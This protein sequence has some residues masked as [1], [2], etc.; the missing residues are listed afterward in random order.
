LDR[1][2]AADAGTASIS[3]EQFLKC[4]TDS[5]LLSAEDI[6]AFLSRLPA[7]QRQD[8][9]QLA[10]QLL[11]QGKLTRFQATMLL[12]GKVKGLVLGNYI[13]L[14]KLGQGGMGMVF[15]ARHRRLDRV[16]ALKVLP[17]AVAKDPK[18]V[19]RF[20]REV[21]AAAQLSHPN[22]V[23][24][25]DADQDRGVHFLVMEFVPGADLAQLVKQRG[26]LPVEQAVA[27]LA[28]AAQGLAHAHAHGIIHRDIK[29]GNLLLDSK[30]TV[31]VLDLGL[32][33]F[34]G[35][36]NAP[37]EGSGTEALTKSGSI[38]GTTDYMAP[39][40]ALNT[41]RADQRADIYSLGCTLYF[42]L[43][44][45]PMYGGETAMEKLLAHR[46]D[47][48][49]PLPNVSK[50]LQAVYTRMVAKKVNDRYP[51]MTEVGADLAAC[52]KGGALTH[53][54]ED[55]ALAAGSQQTEAK[56]GEE[57]WA[58]VGSSPDDSG[59]AQRRKF[60]TG[61]WLLGTGAGALVVLAGLAWLITQGLGEKKD[62]RNVASQSIAP[63]QG[64]ATV[65]PPVENDAAWLK[66]V[67]ALPPEKQVEAVAA[68]LKER[69]P[70]FDGK[71][72]HTV[73]RGVVTRLA[74]ATDNVTDI[75]PVRAL[76]G[77]LIL[78]C[79]ASPGQRGKL[80]DLTPLKSMRLTHLYCLFTK[81]SDLSPLKDMKLTTLYCAGTAVSELSPLKDMALTVLDCRSTQVSDL[82]PLK[83]MQLAVLYCSHSKVSDLLP[84]KGIPLKDLECDF[85]GERDAALVRSI[86]TLERI[87]RK[88]QAEF[89]KE[90]DAQ[91]GAFDAWL[92]A[93][94]AMPPEKQVEAVA[95]K[96]KER[97]PGFDGKVAHT[98][99][100]G[101][102]TELKFVSDNVTDISPVRAL[103]G[104][105][106]LICGGSNVGK[107]NGDLSPLKGMKLTFLHCSY[108]RVSDITPL[109]GMALTTLICQSTQVS[110]LSPLNGMKLT[111]LNCAQTPV[112]D[113]TPLKNMKLESLYCLGTKISDLT[114]L[115]DMPLKDLY[116]DFKPE[117]DAVLLRSIKTLE[118]ING[119]PAA[120]FWKEVD[121]QQAD[122]DAWLKAVA[123]MPPEKQVEAVA[124][125]LKERNPGF[126]GTVKHV[127]A[128]GAV[129]A[130][131]FSTENVTDLLP[132][133]AL[134]ALQSLNCRVPS[135]GTGKLSDLTPLK[136]MK[137]TS[138][139]CTG[140]TQVSDL[141]PLKG[142]SLGQLDCAATAVSDLTPLQGMP[143]TLLRLDLAPVSDLTPLIGMNLTALQCYATK[144]SDLK[145]LR[146]MPLTYLNCGHSKVSD[147]SPLKDMKL[148]SLHCQGTAVA[149]LTPLKNMKLAVLV[150][151]ET[152]VSDLSPLKGM[153]LTILECHTTKV[154][155][156]TP[157]KGMPLIAFEGDIKPERDAAL[158]RGIKTLETINGKAAAEFWKDVDAKKP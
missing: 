93:V 30:G 5:S 36:E 19:Q 148:T 11:Q 32:A 123:A 18:A 84:L 37:Q 41:K 135:G 72:A 58:A 96:L 92:K 144:V 111:W 117:R 61:R 83:N 85:Q 59:L 31:K 70:G 87:N 66:A 143:L 91:Q 45:K 156:W 15:K 28:Q 110:D 120:E 108:S 40:Q 107:G 17:P 124:A 81:V 65:H 131:Q 57:T 106:R 44:G 101:V 145:P 128:G 141:T 34:E 13:V 122:F 90:V 50:K 88:P 116:C 14:N 43:T 3:G 134:T 35:G 22:I 115:K 130:L 102:V 51:S 38:M 132:L 103:A 46:E 138:L 53:S 114:L 94:A 16:V 12:Q 95:A 99:E 79:G 80:A 62:S 151:S 152:N 24:A 71:V 33:R 127:I 86:K 75:A 137:L 157:L 63:T 129:T 73:E 133:R 154:T 76:T 8:A 2:P 136:G 98:T 113:L 64:G 121:G 77:L 100:G 89:W 26:P 119:K 1:T 105:S 146:G 47:P 56:G 78:D 82:S 153:P 97:N 147:L 74:F 139:F 20:R 126:D 25:H 55:L 4:L 60:A 48:I 52:V 149:D 112:S 23:A 142:M 9:R 39:E 125:K 7:P 68:M 42:L 29:P 140:S 109:K 150:C 69:N 54:L 118:K 6:Q 21:Q 67:A 27:C 10:Q 49:P 104:L 158:L 155:D